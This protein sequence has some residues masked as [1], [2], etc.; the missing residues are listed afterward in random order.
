[1][2]T[3]LAGVDQPGAEIES[4]SQAPENP[5][6]FRPDRSEVRLAAA[7]LYGQGYKRPQI[8]R[9]LRPHLITDMMLGRPMDQQLST[10]RAKLRRWERDQKFRDLIYGGAVIKLDLEMPSIFKGIASK[11]KR[12]RVD[13]AR[14]A[15]EITGRHNPKGDQAPTQIALVVNGVPRPR[16][17]VYTGIEHPKVFAEPDGTLVQAPLQDED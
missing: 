13:A 6:I 9:I 12:G 2:G 4:D 3:D 11:A 10:A 8:A 7:K 5:E 14:L 15:L 17:N 16:A 1:M